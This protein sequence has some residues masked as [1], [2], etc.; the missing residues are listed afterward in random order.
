MSGAGKTTLAERLHGRMQKLDFRVELLDGDIIRTNLSHGLGFS[1]E[2]R[3]TN[4]RRIGFVA[5]LLARNGVAVIV[6]AISPYRKVREEVKLKIK[7]FIEIHVD[8]P[9]NVLIKRDT[10]GLYR[11]ALA[12]QIE[13]FTGIS[14]PYEPPADPALVLHTDC[15]TVDRD[16]DKIWRELLVCDYI[17]EEFLPGNQDSG[18]AFAAAGEGI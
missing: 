13:H 15:E 11:M 14:D 18:L 4:I 10:K 5:E 12:G 1:R 8:C 16:T 6:A 3:D 9:L 7:N 17:R 2:D